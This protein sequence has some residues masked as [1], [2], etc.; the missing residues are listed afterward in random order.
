ML[1]SISSEHID[2][3]S[4]RALP[5]HRASYIHGKSQ[6]QSLIQ[7]IN[8]VSTSDFNC[9]SKHWTQLRYER[10]NESNHKINVGFEVLTAVLIKSSVFW[11]ITPCSPLK[12]KPTFRRNISPP[13]LGSKNKTE[14]ETR[15]KAGGKQSRTC[16]VYFSTLKMEATCSSETSIY[17][18][19]IIRRYIREDRTL[20]KINTWCSGS[21]LRAPNSSS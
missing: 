2:H 18:Q 14:Q 16:S 10:I 11:D 20:H 12:V 9:T 4:T 17:F 19:R 13:S 15:L 1:Y 8:L 7:Y 21:I 6:D 5:Q 3:C